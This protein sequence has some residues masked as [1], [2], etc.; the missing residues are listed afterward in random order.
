MRW[1]GCSSASSIVLHEGSGVDSTVGWLMLTGAF[2]AVANASFGLISVM[3]LGYSPAAA[4]L[5][6]ALGATLF[7]AYRSYA[8]L[9][10]HYSHLVSLRGYTESLGTAIALA[11]CCARSCAEGT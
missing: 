3:A 5:L 4:V 7:V 10:R 2:A 8:S 1:A 11:G 6:S 9:R